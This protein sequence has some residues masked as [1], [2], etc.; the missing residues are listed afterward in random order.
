MCATSW[1]FLVLLFLV[2]YESTGTS[3]IMENYTCSD[4][5]CFYSSEQSQL[6]CNTQGGINALRLDSNITS[7][8]TIFNT[9][10]LQNYKDYHDNK[11]NFD[12][13]LLFELS[14]YLR[15]SSLVKLTDLSKINYLIYIA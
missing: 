14:L 3:N 15:P 5:K 2:E 6:C 11:N 8:G 10:L 9:F 1:L 12:P 13:K 4:W 7:I